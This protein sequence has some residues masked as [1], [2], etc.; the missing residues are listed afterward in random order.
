MITYEKTKNGYKDEK[1]HFKSWKKAMLHFLSTSKCGTQK[2]MIVVSVNWE[3]I[4]MQEDTLILDQEKITYTGGVNEM[5]PLVAN[6]A[7]LLTERKLGE[8]QKFLDLLPGS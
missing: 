2:P 6:V 4:V 7:K 5:S 3:S 8:A 1:V